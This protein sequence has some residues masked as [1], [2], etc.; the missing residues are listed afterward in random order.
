MFL[1]PYIHEAASA[2]ALPC[3]SSLRPHRPLSLKLALGPAEKT[4]QL[5][6]Q[7]TAQ[8]S[9][10]QLD[11][12][13]ANSNSMIPT[14]YSRSLIKTSISTRPGIS[15]WEEY[16]LTLPGWQ[17]LTANTWVWTQCCFRTSGNLL[18]HKGF[19]KT[20]VWLKYCKACPGVT[21]DPAS[22][23]PTRLPGNQPLLVFWDI[24]TSAQK[25]NG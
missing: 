7:A 9:T 17:W 6:S 4:L 12:P 2:H 22:R 16:W 13:S 21:F 14:S 24:S 18:S 3:S 5:W 1:K 25:A 19:N 10:C 23:V 8:H 20:A 15:R 11:A